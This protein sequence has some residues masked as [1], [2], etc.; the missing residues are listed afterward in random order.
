VCIGQIAKC[1]PKVAEN[2]RLKH[3]KLEEELGSINKVSWLLNQSGASTTLGSFLVSQLKALRWHP[4]SIDKDC[5]KN[6]PYSYSKK[7]Q[8]KINCKII[9]HPSL[10]TDQLKASKLESI[11]I[12]EKHQSLGIVVQA[13]MGSSRLPGKVAKKVGGKEYLRHQIDRILK[14][15]PPSRCIIAT[16]LRQEDDIVCEMAVKSGVQFFR[17]SS[18]DVLKRYIDAAEDFRF[19]DVVRL[20]GDCPLIDPYIMNEIIRVYSEIKS[21]SKYV[22]NTLFRT[23]PRGF[24]VEVTTLQ[25][26]K[27]AWDSSKSE[28]DH[29]HVTPYI[30]SGAIGGC[31]RVNCSLNENL[32]GWRFTLDTI[33]DHLQLSRILESMDSYEMENV[34]RYAIN[35]SLLRAD[36]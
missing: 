24:D 30:K 20:T 1:R 22:S 15:C 13:R 36:S 8:S 16:T 25:D 11:S 17:G 34:I 21:K 2:A 6:Q 31:I 23:F 35:N 32:S 28:Y 14:K 27:T 19:T 29:E 18:Q 33:D 5:S 26:L 12:F 3:K 9:E 4:L 7:N 10:T